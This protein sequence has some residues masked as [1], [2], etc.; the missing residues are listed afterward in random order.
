MDAGMNNNQSRKRRDYKMTTHY[1]KMTPIYPVIKSHIHFLLRFPIE[2]G[3]SEFSQAHLPAGSLVSQG[4]LSLEFSGFVT[5]SPQ[6]ES[7]V[8]QAVAKGS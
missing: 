7:D 3:W 8:R 6:R 1:E 4:R 5:P 2:G